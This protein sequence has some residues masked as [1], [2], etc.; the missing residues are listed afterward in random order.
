MS[1]VELVSVTTSDGVSLDGTLRRP[2]AMPSFLGVDAVFLH[3]G[4]AGSFYRPSFFG[5]LQEWFAAQGVAVLRVNSRGHDLASPSAGG[6]IGASYEV[7]EDCVHDWRAWTNFAQA[8]GYPRVLLWGHSLGAVKTLYYLA[9]ERDE[10]VICAIASSP[11]R[12][13]YDD[14]MSRPDGPKLAAYCEQAAALIRAGKPQELLH[15]SVPRD[16]PAMSAR[17]YL[18][19]WGPGERYNHL[20]LLREVAV[21]VLV[22]VGSEEGKT[23]DSN[24]WLQ[25]CE[26]APAL[27][28][29]AKST[30]GVSFELID[31]A[32]HA[33]A[34]K[35]AHLSEVAGRWLQETLH[36]P[37]GRR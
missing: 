10:H 36:Q 31:G 13:S 29:V 26:V 8:Q 9:N 32:N 2:N 14:A 6:V 37:A 3:H 15:A 16:F 33:Y 30:P 34:G 5:A 1:L 25:F 19:K 24:D 21:P 35:S 20:R 4:F 17:T 22:T 27:V 11:P 23:P 28:E 18:D 7:M 12:F